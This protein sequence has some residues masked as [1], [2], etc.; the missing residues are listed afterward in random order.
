[1]PV[2]LALGGARGGASIVDDDVAVWAS[3]YSWHQHS[4]GY[5]RAKLDGSVRCLH[6]VIAERH[7]GILPT[8]VVDHRDG[9][10]LNNLRTNLRVCSQ[11]QNA[12]NSRTSRNNKSGHRGVCWD[13]ARAKWL[14]HIKVDYK[15]KNLGWFQSFDDAVAARLKAET[16]Y[17]GDFAP[18]H[19]VCK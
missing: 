12:R 2:E 3:R 5:V 6:R 13:K 9:N 8:E 11:R 17:F 16:E 10:P 7:L 4:T 15:F 14:A 18:A 1:M 19:G